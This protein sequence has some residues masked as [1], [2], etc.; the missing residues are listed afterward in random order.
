[1][2]ATETR[3]DRKAKGLA[4]THQNMGSLAVDFR[5]SEKAKKDAGQETITERRAGRILSAR[6][7]S[8]YQR[9]VTAPAEAEQA[10]SS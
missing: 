1:M 6:A 8:E 5:A 9:T 3:E 7:D 10:R 2:T 4:S